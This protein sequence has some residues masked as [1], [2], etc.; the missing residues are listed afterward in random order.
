MI[1]RDRSY[2]ISPSQITGNQPQIS[3]LMRAILFDWMM[4][5]TNEFT[6]K[7]ETYHLA[8]AYVDRYL[9]FGPKIP[10]SEF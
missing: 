4:E 2:A 7:R 8:L 10:K 3:P 6:L 5:I 1:S 9:A